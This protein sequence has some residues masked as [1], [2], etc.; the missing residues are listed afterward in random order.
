MTIQ[1]LAEWAIR[2]SILIL[3]GASLLWALR[4]K[5]AA[6]RLAAW[7]GKL[8]GSLAI[9]AITGALPGVPL[10]VMRVATRPLQA[11]VVGYEAV[12]APAVLGPDAGLPT[13]GVAVSRRFDWARAG[14]IV[15]VLVVGAL[16]ARGT[17]FQ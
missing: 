16:L 15:Y 8:F 14:V 7:T 5:D 3:S 11:P 6:I 9:P 17:F 2:S 13:G 1:F 12:P 4:V 10:A